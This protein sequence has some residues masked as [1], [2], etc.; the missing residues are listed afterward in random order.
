MA[1]QN[2]FNGCAEIVSDRCIRYTGVDIPSLGIATGDSLSNIEASLS[3]FLISALNG[4]GIHPVID[5]DIL[6][7][8]INKYLPT[9]RP[10][11]IIDFIDTLIKATCDL[12]EQVN[13]N[14]SAIATLNADYTIGCLTGVVASSDTHLIV[15]AV[16]TKLCSV[17]T[18]LTALSLTLS[19]NYS[20]NGAELDAYIANYL[21]THGASTTLMSNK[22]IP[23]V[24]YPYFGN[25]TG[26]FD[27]TGAGI[28]ATDWVNVNL[29]NGLHGTPDMRG[30]VP[31]GATTMGTITVDPRT[32]PGGAN[33]SYIVGGSLYGYNSILLDATTVP[34]HT[35]TA[36]A[37]ASVPSHFHYEFSNTDATGT[38]SRVSTLTYPN[39]VKQW[40][41]TTAYS[42]EIEGS[43]TIP[44]LGKTD[45]VPLVITV[46]SVTVA[47]TT[48][49]GNAHSNIQ[50]S[51]ASYYIMYI[52]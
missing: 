21:T 4:I 10:L 44:T 25:L 8:L 20:S 22:M 13:I 29:C 23:Y 28:P 50:P 32:A 18:T 1:C 49:G 45:S 48:L 12:Q 14:T 36:T 5:P 37:T 6:C 30:L 31:V 42:Y 11:T 24:A 33:P 47:P 7:S 19:T 17:D 39:V 9:C 43:L 15:Q 3:T 51:I 46:N 2:C 34:N 26:K 52:P 38:N 16:I 27:G 41:D 35:H 40:G